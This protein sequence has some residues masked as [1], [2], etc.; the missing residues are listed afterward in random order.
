MENPR[1]IENEVGSEEG[2][3]REHDLILS[4]NSFPRVV[5]PGMHEASVLCSNSALRKG[6]CDVLINSFLDMKKYM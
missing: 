6:H 3:L 1:T 2:S 4:P 5:Y